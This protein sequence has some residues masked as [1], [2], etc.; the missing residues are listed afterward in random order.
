MSDLR[1]DNIYYAINAL[2]REAERLSWNAQGIEQR[3]RARDLAR[4]AKEA[5]AE[6]RILSEA[7][8]RLQA[9]KSEAD[10]QYDSYVTR[11]RFEDEGGCSCHISAPCS[12][13]TRQTDD[14]DEPLPKPPVC[15]DIV[16]G[17][18]K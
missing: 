4:T 10:R 16:L 18:R 17:E 6:Y 8:P 7:M 5:A 2:E 1:I 9:L 14:E 15:S 13:C 12:F 3:D 11:P